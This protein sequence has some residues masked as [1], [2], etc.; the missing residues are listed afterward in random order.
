MDSVS[1]DA[2]A[3]KLDAR[4]RPTGG[5][6]SK[7]R[8]EGLRR[9]QLLPATGPMDLGNQPGAASFVAYVEL[10]G[11][12]SPKWFTLYATEIRRPAEKDLDIRVSRDLRLCGIYKLDGDK[13]VVCL[14]EAEGSP[15]LRPT[16]FR[17]DGEGGLYLLTYQ[18][19]TK[20]WKTDVRPAPTPPPVTPNLPTVPTV[21]PG[22][23]E[24]PVPS[25]DVPPVGPLVPPSP[26]TGGAPPPGVLLPPAIGPGPMEIPLPVAPVERAPS[27]SLPQATDPTPPRAE[28][29]PSDLDRLQGVW[30]M[31]QLDGK[32]ATGD[33]DTLEILKDRVLASD[34]THGRIRVDEARSPAATHP[35]AGQAADRQ[36]DRHLQAGGR[37]S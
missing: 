23:A 7:Q 13:L 30:V 2:A 3:A 18:R 5:E 24:G 4:G 9:L 14:P 33:S 11:T 28:P 15:L 27:V 36:G 19:P 35:H 32:P 37:S 16:D 17:G 10:D 6:R 34:G 8:W 26:P 22:V 1:P 29:A 20:N 21:P 31:S 25:A 12:R